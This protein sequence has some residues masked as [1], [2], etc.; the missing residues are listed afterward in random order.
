MAQ[1][2]Y[3]IVWMAPYCA[4][5]R[6]GSKQTEFQLKTHSYQEISSRLKRKSIEHRLKLIES[7]WIS[8]EN[9]HMSK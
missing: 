9:E 2:L 4:Q 1:I 5:Q 3:R 6:L 8:I 7:E